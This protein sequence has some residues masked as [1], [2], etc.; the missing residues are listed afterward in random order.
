MAFRDVYEVLELAFRETVAR[1]KNP[2]HDPP[3]LTPNDRLVWAVLAHHKNHK[4][5]LCKPGYERLMK[6]TGLGRT[7]LSESIQRLK[8]RITV[9]RNG[10][11]N[12]YRWESPASPDEPFEGEVRETNF[13]SSGDELQKAAKR[14]SEVRETASN[15]VFKSGRE[16]G[17]EAGSSS[18]QNSSHR[19]S[20]TGSTPN[21][22]NPHPP[23]TQ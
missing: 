17:S 5:G 18:H 16:T 21:P 8:S 10:R 13:S 14:I 20:N 7:A 15:R 11:A 4:T 9:D 23:Y 2:E 19:D 6:F 1:E 3:P 12:T 22:P